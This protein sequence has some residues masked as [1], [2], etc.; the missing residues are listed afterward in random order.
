MGVDE[1]LDGLNEFEKSLIVYLRSNLIDPLAA[2]EIIAKQNPG[3]SETKFLSA[4][5]G[6]ITPKELKE[7]LDYTVIAQDDAKVLLSTV[8][9][10]HFRN[11]LL[12]HEDY[13]KRNVIL[14]GKSGTGKTLLV[15]TLA[16]YFSL[17]YTEVDSTQITQKGYSGLDPEDILFNL[18]EKANWNIDKASKG[19]VILDEI[20]KLRFTPHKGVSGATAQNNLNKMV[21]GTTYDLLDLFGEGKKK[22][23]LRHLAKNN[24]FYTKINT[25][26]ILFIG[27][28]AFQDLLGRKAKG[29]G[30]NNTQSLNGSYNK[31][32]LTI[33]DF[34][35]A[36]FNTEFIGRFNN[37]V[38]LRSLTAK[39]Y[40][41]ILKKSNVSPLSDIAHNFFLYGINVEFTDNFLKEVSERAYNHNKTGARYLKTVLNDFMLRYEY[42]LPSM[43]IKYVKFNKESLTNPDK[44][45]S[46]LIKSPRV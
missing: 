39:D 18:V 7:T 10:T 29:I 40:Y 43:N 37:V 45:L 12:P 46:N 34:I 8:F 6:L 42:E 4:K 41:N 35:E 44:F 28:G 19:V 23:V 14:V 1:E 33:E 24:R 2:K 3:S 20:D 26:N 15:R 30:F 38:N 13:Q 32:N 16:E 27:A 17:P 9:C 25:K 22:K 31:I 36:G 21:E 11:Y 5:T